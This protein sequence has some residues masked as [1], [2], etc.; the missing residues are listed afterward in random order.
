VTQVF[1]V[2]D[3]AIEL[4]WPVLRRGEHVIEVGD[5]TCTVVGDDAPAAIWVGDLPPDTVLDVVVDG[6]RVATTRTLAPPPGPRLARI[7]TISDLHI[8]D[9][10]RFGK[11]PTLEHPGGDDDAI[12]V[13]CTR[14]ALAEIAAWDPDLL[15]VKGDVTHH[16]TA[17][18]WEIVAPL[19]AE[20]GVPTI[21]TVGNHD[22]KLGPAV[23][24]DVL[25][26]HD[27][28]LVTSG[29]AVRD[30]PGIR[31]VVADATL[32]NRHRGSFGS[33]GDS[34]LEAVGSTPGAAFL[35]VHHQLHR[36]PALVHWPPGILGGDTFVR[37]IAAANPDT[38]A[39][40]G[41]THR[42]RRR[43]VGSVVVTEVG[44]PKDYPGTWAGYAVHEGGIRQVVRR[45]ADPA[46]L[47]WTEQTK[48]ALFGAW[49]RWSPG[50]LRDRCFSHHWRGR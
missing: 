6:R 39:T 20:T 17:A 46:V 44:S 28:E 11:W 4:C 18:E 37:T 3:T 13:R 45:T 42:H 48:L 5:T 25:A 36:V 29:V 22:V 30:L 35:A 2:E 32:P 49:G 24:V 40:S 15:V 14:A 19:L 43:Q 1:A 8:G 9:G 33:V 27:I 12:V 41:H 47:E 31:V 7:A 34:I 26:E 38:L 10:W 50:R 23:G 21:A 16:G